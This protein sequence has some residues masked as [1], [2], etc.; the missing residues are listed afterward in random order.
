MIDKNDRLKRS[1]KITG[2]NDRRKGS[3]AFIRNWDF[4][5]PYA[6]AAAMGRRIGHPYQNRTPPKRKKPRTS[7]SRLQ[8][9]NALA[10]FSMSLT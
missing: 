6:L 1:T 4:S 2:K 5:G 9:K 7:F 8:V 3:T 10:Y